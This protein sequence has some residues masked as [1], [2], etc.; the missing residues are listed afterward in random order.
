MLEGTSHHL[1]VSTNWSGFSYRIG[2]LGLILCMPMRVPCLLWYITPYSFRKSYNLEPLLE[3]NICICT[4]N[5][6][7]PHPL[8]SRVGKKMFVSAFSRK[9]IFSCRK[10]FLTKNDINYDNV[11][12]ITK[13]TT[14]V[15]SPE[16][17][18]NIQISVEQ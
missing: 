9:L 14:L 4:C 10:N 5:F 13:Q 17:D 11:G 2:V 16:N 12:E 3:R 6:P 7:P 8:R 15:K 18:R 1:L